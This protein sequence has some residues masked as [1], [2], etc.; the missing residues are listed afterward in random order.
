MR[1]HGAAARH[2]DSTAANS[3]RWNKSKSP[4]GASRASLREP[5]ESLLALALRRAAGHRGTEVRRRQSSR[6]IWTGDHKSMRT[7]D[8]LGGGTSSGR[9]QARTSVVGAKDP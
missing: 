4:L 2:P 5:R 9:D 6:G 1:F 7:R 8:A 3:F